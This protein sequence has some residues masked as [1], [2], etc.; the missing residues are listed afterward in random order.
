METQYAASTV[1]MDNTGYSDLQNQILGV[2][3]E[4]NAPKAE[5]K[6]EKP[7]PKQSKKEPSAVTKKMVFKRGDETLEMDEDFELE[8]MAD[9]RPIKLTLRELKDR[10]AG[11]YAIKNRMHALAEEK[12]KIQATIKEFASIAKSDPLASL[13]FIS[14]MANEADSEFEYNKYLEAL[15]EQAEKLGQMDEKER[16]AWELE[17][18]L[19]KAEQNLS[20]QEREANVVLRKQDILE[21]YPEIGN[22]EFE[23]MVEKVL[24]DEALTEKVQDEAGFMDLMEDLVVETLTQRDIIKVISDINPDYINDDELIFTLADQL[25]QNP[26][27]DE[28]D[29]RDI[30][31]ELIKPARKKQAEPSTPREM[32][33]RTLSHKARQSAPVEHIAAQG[34]SDYDLLKEQ[35]LENYEKIKHTPKNKR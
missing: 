21:T 34:G 29:V 8:M 28:E 18:K 25:R 33:A 30:I 31:G 14:K 24:S 2:K 1:Q 26:D 3:Q 35:L 6:S 17:K 13:E 12:K 10:A 7:E 4:K 9:K 23:E 16:K 19:T 5:P 22:S 15:A 11:D 20:R 32:A 27:F